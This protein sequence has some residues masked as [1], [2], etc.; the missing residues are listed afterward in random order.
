MSLTPISD[1]G[2][3][4]TEDIKR[5]L[6]DHAEIYEAICELGLYDDNSITISNVWRSFA[7]RETLCYASRLNSYVIGSDLMLYKCSVHFD[8]ADNHIGRILPSGEAEIDEYVHRKWH[9][10]R[11][12]SDMCKSCFFLPSCHGGACPYQRM[13]SEESSKKCHYPNWKNNIGN[14]VKYIEKKFGSEIIRIPT[15]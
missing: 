10:N 3:N 13:F 1:M 2:G 14:A 5:Q 8:M 11:S 12:L 7:P 15:E 6:I 4:M 9:M